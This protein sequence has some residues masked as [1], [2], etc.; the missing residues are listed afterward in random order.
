MVPEPARRVI[1]NERAT[2]GDGTSD[3]NPTKFVDLLI[4]QA[5]TDYLAARGQGGVHVFDR[6]LPDT[7]A[8]A[9]ALGVD[10]GRAKVVA[11]EYR[12]MPK[13]FLAP[14]W[15]DIF[16][17]DQERTLT[18]AATAQFSH[19]LETAYRTLGYEWH[20]LPRVSVCE[21]AAFVESELK[22]TP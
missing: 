14:P 21:R 1:A 7:I 18:F 22:K 10:A 6:G 9:H 12:Y 13:V 5:Q 8:Y 11:N 2:G 20:L 19:L 3:R 17:N 16:E 15:Q 4:T